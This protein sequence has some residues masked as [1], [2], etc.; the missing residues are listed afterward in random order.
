MELVPFRLIAVCT[1]Y[2]PSAYGRENFTSQAQDLGL[3]GE[4]IR[5]ELRQSTSGEVLGDWSSHQDGPWEA[6]VLHSLP[7]MGGA[8]D[9]SGIHALAE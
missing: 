8:L 3:V 6:T 1:V 2:D 5:G 7:R 4:F 9:A